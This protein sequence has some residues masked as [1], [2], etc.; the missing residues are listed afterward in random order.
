MTSKAFLSAIAA[1][2]LFAAPAAAQI[3]NEA[4]AKDVPTKVEFIIA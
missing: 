2:G 4:G 3:D 1:L